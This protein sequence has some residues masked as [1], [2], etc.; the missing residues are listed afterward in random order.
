MTE[1][2][3]KYTPP[4][5]RVIVFQLTLNP[6]T[7]QMQQ[8]H[9]HLGAVRFSYNWAL[10]LIQRNYLDFQKDPTVDRLKI[11]HTSILK[12]WNLAKTEIAPWWQDNAKEAYDTGILN[13]VA[14]YQNFFK[15]HSGVIRGRKL[16]Y[17]KFKKSNAQNQI[18][19]MFVNVARLDSK[20]KH[21][22]LSRIGKVSYY[23][24]ADSV[25]WLL[26]NGARITQGKLK[27]NQTR[28]TF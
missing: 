8:F 15:S 5:G 25:K 2:K 23:G 3:R 12:Q 19:C 10:E 16:G 9:S 22:Y 24:D 13:A 26:S 11:G 27:H 7:D 17:P 18:G 14:A 1:G 6:T 20:S 21:V 4:T 28:W